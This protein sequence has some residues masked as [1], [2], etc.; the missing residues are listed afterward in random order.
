MKKILKNITLFITCWRIPGSC[1]APAAFCKVNV[2]SEA[3]IGFHI[4]FLK[5]GLAIGGG[6]G[7]MK[8]SMPSFDK[9]VTKIIMQ[10]YTKCKETFFAAAWTF[11][12]Y[13][14]HLN[15]SCESVFVRLGDI[16]YTFLA[17]KACVCSHLVK[18][19]KK[20]NK[21]HYENMF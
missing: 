17:R 7:S 16:A 3:A 18:H 13:R 12:L 1:S 19:Y 15:M 11:A 5:S 20:Y 4:W 8:L 10:L 6:R 9:I 21:K 14:K 2:V